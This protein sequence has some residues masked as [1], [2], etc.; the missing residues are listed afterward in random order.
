MGIRP[1]A[2]G[3]RLNPPLDTV[4]APGDKLIVNDIDTRNFF[5]EVVGEVKKIGPVEVPK[6][7]SFFEIFTAPSGVCP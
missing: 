3:V 4:L 6:S 1:A 5:L 7:G 2:G